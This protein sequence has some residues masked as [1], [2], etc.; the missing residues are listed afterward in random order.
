[1]SALASVCVNDNLAACKT[2]VTVRTSD[3]KLSCRVDKILDVVVKQRKH[4]LAVNLLLDTRHEDILHVFLYTCQHSVIVRVK[5]VVLCRN[6]DGVY[7]AGLA[8][9]VVFNRNLAL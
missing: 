7:A 2:S 8:V 9:V 5:L 1:M 4:L 3:N 6:H